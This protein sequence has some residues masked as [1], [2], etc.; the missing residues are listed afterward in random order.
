M[1]EE[2]HA[3]PRV[4]TA[5]HVDDLARVVAPELGAKDAE[6]E[7]LTR[8]LRVSQAKVDGAALY[9]DRVNARVAMLE[10]VVTAYDGIHEER[11]R[12]RLAWLSARRRAADEANFGMEALERK[13]YE[14]S[15]A[16]TAHSEAQEAWVDA[17]NRLD[18]ATTNVVRLRAFA[19]DV[20]AVRG[21]CMDG[22]PDCTR[23]FLSAAYDS[24]YELEAAEREGRPFADRIQR[25]A[26]R[27]EFDDVNA[28]EA[29]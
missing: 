6:I 17:E 3:W 15:R 12:Y 28:D 8:D 22:E 29:P 13:N 23:R 24:M 27:G 16:W 10:N 2:V 1:V 4:T 7:R 18:D 21:W 14:L 5:E 20:I 9:V 25:R 26:A 11:D 19:A